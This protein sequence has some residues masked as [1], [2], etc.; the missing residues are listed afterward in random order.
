MSKSQHSTREA[1]KKPLLSP[2][3]KRMAKHAKK[4][5]HDT[6]PLLHETPPLVTH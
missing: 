4:H 2:K 5:S 6:V 3:E 1:K